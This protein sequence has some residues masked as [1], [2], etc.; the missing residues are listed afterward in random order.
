MGWQTTALF[1]IS[2]LLLVSK[3]SWHFF[4]DNDDDY[5]YLK[6]FQVEHTLPLHLE[7]WLKTEALFQLSVFWNR[8]VAK[9]FLSEEP[10]SHSSDSFVVVAHLEHI[11]NENKTETFPV[12]SG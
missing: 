5:F 2:S 6:I 9:T 11:L 4:D 1:H 10:N 7:T 8:D 12:Y 3:L